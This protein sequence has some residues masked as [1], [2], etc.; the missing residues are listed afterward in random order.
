M[1]VNYSNWT[2]PSS[3]AGD[4]LAI[5][6]AILYIAVQG[7]PSEN[8]QCFGTAFHLDRRQ[9]EAGRGIE[10]SGR[11]CLKAYDESCCRAR[12]RAR[13]GQGCPDAAHAEAQKRSDGMD[14]KL[15]EQ[16]KSAEANIAEARAKA[17]GDI[18]AAT[19]EVAAA[20]VE[21]LI[22]EKI[23]NV[24]END[25]ARRYDEGVGS[26][27]T[28]WASNAAHGAFHENA[29]FWVAVA[30]ALLF[31]LFGKKIFA[32]IT[33]G[34][35]SRAETIRDE[36][37]EA[38]RL[39]EE[40]QELLAGYQRKQ[41]EAA[42]EAEAIVERA[43]AEADRLAE[44]AAAHLEESL[45]RRERQAMDRIAQAEAGD[46][47]DSESAV[48][49]AVSATGNLTDNLS[50]AKADALIAGAIKIPGKFH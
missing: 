8:R 33:S 49:L 26:M 11:V 40:A 21:K 48:D 29:V 27:G 1:A 37:D 16:V 43:K 41:H 31:V 44:K 47:G 19:A 46:E 5:S 32:A 12:G 23:D 36:I 2:L 50:D 9:P 42:K 20:A 4:R 3:P 15:A 25:A 24:V 30:F 18:K 35:D 10:T 38:T 7:R 14:V 34:L 39:R 17:M 22:G 13:A 45:K 28:A 6:F